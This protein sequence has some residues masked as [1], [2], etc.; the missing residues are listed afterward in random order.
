MKLTQT[1]IV[2][3]NKAD[4]ALFLESKW[5]VASVGF[6]NGDEWT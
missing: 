1:T 4:T 5:E 3:S 2:L 6:T